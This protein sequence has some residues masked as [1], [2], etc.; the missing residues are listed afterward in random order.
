MHFKKLYILSL[1]SAAFLTIS[2]VA[3]AG[4]PYETDDP[5]PTEYKHYEIF[6]ASEYHRSAEEESG[7]LPHLEV[8]YGLMP[9]VQIAISIPNAFSETQGQSRHYG[10]GD[11][12]LGVKYRFIQ[13]TETTP[14]V[15]FYPSYKSHTGN[16]HK[17]LGN[18][19]NEYFLPI[20]LSKS[21]GEWTT[22]G[23]GGYT[24]TQEV[25]A[26]NHWFFGW[27]LEKQITEHLALGGEVFHESEESSDEGSSTG[28]NLGGSY[29]FSER[30]HVVF[31]AGKGLKNAQ[32]T[33]RFS[34][35]VAYLL[36][37]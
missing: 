36:T 11:I 26:K 12:E 10:L 37:F 25:D 13:E 16:D 5:D 28:F 27:L 6:V 30:H 32:Q 4:P 8:N 21:W 17:G 19:A 1:L 7:T 18:D 34:S 29:D 23:G 15:A 9:D 22:Y 35:Y 2:S 31:S 20:W 24:I 3:F 14:M 33:N